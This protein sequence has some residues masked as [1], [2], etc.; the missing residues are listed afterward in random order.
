MMLLNNHTDN[1]E[2]MQL[3]ELEL[4]EIPPNQ[5]QITKLSKDKEQE[6]SNENCQ[7]GDVI[8]AALHN[9]LQKLMFAAN[10]GQVNGVQLY[11]ILLRETS[12]H[13][14]AIAEIQKA[15][16]STSKTPSQNFVVQNGSSDSG[17]KNDADLQNEPVKGE[18]KMYFGQS[19]L[20]YV[21]HNKI[22]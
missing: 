16:R 8:F 12:L 6:N 11:E 2:F 18:P 19:P 17:F 7:S 9:S 21:P 3:P 5:I 22:P 15:Q 10:S 14:R 20:E 1:E 13:E 4:V